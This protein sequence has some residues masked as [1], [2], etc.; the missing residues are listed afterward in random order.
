MD[1]I[2]IWT[3]IE[4]WLLYA[5]AGTFCLFMAMALVLRRGKWPTYASFAG[6][7]LIIAALLLGWYETRRLPWDNLY[8]ASAAIA[9]II[10]A[11]SSYCYRRKK[12]PALY[13]LLAAATAL[14]LLFSAVYI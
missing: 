10:G 11:V 13:L 1:I 5:A 9:L 7:L 14:L 6:C 12:A 3:D 8:E 2:I 4:Q